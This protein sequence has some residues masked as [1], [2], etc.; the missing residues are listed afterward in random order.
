MC[1]NNGQSLDLQSALAQV[2]Q[3]DVDAIIDLPYRHDTVMAPEYLIIPF[4]V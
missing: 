3:F 2:A 1:W 4:D